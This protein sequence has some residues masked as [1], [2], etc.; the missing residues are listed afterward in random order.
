MSTR[1]KIEQENACAID[2][3]P[4]RQDG[5]PASVYASHLV[6]RDKSVQT[7]SP[8]TDRNSTFPNTETEHITFH[9][10]KGN[11]GYA[12]SHP[13]P[14]E[15]S[16][17]FVAHVDWLG[18]TLALSEGKALSWLFQELHSIFGL[19]V[20]QT[21]NAGWNGYSHRAELGRYGLIAWGGKAQRGTAH[22]EINGMGCAQILDW[23]KI[24]AWGI[25]NRARITRIDLA[26]DDLEG[27]LC[28]I[29]RTLQWHESGG[30]NCGGRNA[31]VKLAGDWHDLTDGRTVYIGTRGNKMLRCYEKGK[32]LDDRESPWF[33]VEL[34]LRNKNRL[35]PWDML[36][37]PGQYL[38]GSYPC[39]A[40]LS[41][42]QSKLRTTQKATTISL[43]C[44]TGNA[45]RLS[46]KA[47]NVLMQLHQEDASTVVELLRRQGLPKRLE[48][49]EDNLKAMSE[50]DID[51]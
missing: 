45:A 37:R 23:K 29:E 35:L 14:R 24:E 47:I 11:Q 21:K 9:I 43:D 8:V 42:D 38:A 10:G 25:E 28:N 22:I 50:K 13:I 36:T 39:L 17:S 5:Q 2:R 40:F 32:Q 12:I 4:A 49:Y 18:I 34:E 19:G 31:K 7:H 16:S 6:I 51:S 41:T 33:R 48:P 46:G 30:F 15:S 3:L 44:M 20:T 1:N 27:L 26:H